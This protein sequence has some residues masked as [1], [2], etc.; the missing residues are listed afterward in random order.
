MVL[1]AFEMPFPFLS[2][3]PKIERSSV[4]RDVSRLLDKEL[5]QWRTRPTGKIAFLQLAVRYENV[6]QDGYVMSQYE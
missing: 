4:L 2:M 5:E 3:G 1:K 6:R